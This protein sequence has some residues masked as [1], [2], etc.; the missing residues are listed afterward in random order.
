MEKKC[1]YLFFGDP[2][3]GALCCVELAY[4]PSEE[5]QKNL[6][7]MLDLH[8]VCVTPKQIY[9]HKIK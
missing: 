1:H 5:Q 6:R 3:K 8:Y 2:R 9:E 4:A 7:E